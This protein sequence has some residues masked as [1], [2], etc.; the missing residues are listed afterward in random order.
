MLKKYFSHLILTILIVVLGITNFR[1]NKIL[2]GWD[3][4]HPEFLP[5]DNFLNKT[6]F[7]VWNENYGLGTVIANSSYAE[8][9]RLPLY[10]FLQ[11]IVGTDYVRFFWHL[12]L[13]GIGGFGALYFTNFLLKK[14]DI[15]FEKE[16]IGL[17]AL[18]SSFFYILN[19]GSVQ[20]N[21]LPYE[22]FSYFFM[23][24]PW[25][26]FSLLRFMSEP[27]S[28]KGILIFFTINLFATPSFSN[29]PL[30]IVYTS[31]TFFLIFSMFIFRSSK[32]T[33]S[34]KLFTKSFYTVL[35]FTISNLFWILPYSYF[36]F[37]GKPA[38]VLQSKTYENFSS[39]AQIRN[40]IGGI[41]EN[42]IFL[43]GF[44][45]NTLDGEFNGGGKYV[46]GDW[47][48]YFSLPQV[49]IIYTIFLGL[50]VTGIFYL[51]FKKF[52]FLSFFLSLSFL[53]I[54]IIL[55]GS[56]P[57]FGFIVSF[58]RD[59]VP[60]FSQVFRFSF[61][62]FIVP[63]SLFYSILL[64]IGVY[65]LIMVVHKI[66][67]KLSY[68]LLYISAVVSFIFLTLVYSYPAFSGNYF[69]P[70][71]FVSIPNSYTKISEI[72]KTE[73]KQ[74]SG[75]VLILPTPSHLAW[76]AF[77]W[78]YRGSG[79]FWFQN[80]NP[81]LS[82]TFD[83]HSNY[84]QKSFE[85]IS[86]ALNSKNIS[87]F[88]KLLQKYQI[89]WILVDNSDYFIK[90]QV[91]K[92][93][94]SQSIEK[95]NLEKV[96]E[97]ED[98]E[99]SL[100]K[101]KLQYDKSYQLVKKGA[102]FLID[103]DYYFSGNY[104]VSEKSSKIK[105]FQN[106]D[107]EKIK[108]LDFIEKEVTLKTS[109]KIPN[110][111]F[112]A[113]A[114]FSLNKT[115]SGFSLNPVL[116]KIFINEKLVDLSN[117]QFNQ[118]IL[119]NEETPIIRVGKDVY[120]YEQEKSNLLTKKLNEKFEM[121]VYPNKFISL[122]KLDASS[123]L[124]SLGNCAS[125]EKLNSVFEASF[126]SN[127]LKLGGRNSIPCV[128]FDTKELKKGLYKLEAKI[129]TTRPENLR[130]CIYEK[131]SCLKEFFYKIVPLQN[132]YKFYFY[133]DK[134]LKESKIYL[135]LDANKQSLS[136]EIVFSSVDLT[137][138]ASDGSFY[139]L[140][141][142]LT[143]LF[144]NEGYIIDI[145]LEK[146]D[147]IKYFINNNIDNAKLNYQEDISQNSYN[148]S[149]YCFYKD[150]D[151]Q[152]EILNEGG[153][154]FYRYTST[155]RP[156]CDNILLG[157]M[158][159]GLGYIMKVEY[160]NYNQGGMNL[161]LNDNVSEFCYIDEYLNKDYEPLVKIFP[162]ISGSGYGESNL[163][164]YLGSN[165]RDFKDKR[166]TDISKISFT[167][168]PVFWLQDINLTGD[169]NSQST[170][171]YKADRILPFLYFYNGPVLKGSVVGTGQGFDKGWVALCGVSLCSSLVELV[172]INNWSG[173][174]LNSSEE[175][176]NGIVILFWPQFL[177]FLGLGISFLFFFTIVFYQSR[178]KNQTE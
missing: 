42:S 49:Q 135:A 62:K 16:G 109:L 162:G 98:K 94:T 43:K 99:Q 95:L 40:N 143:S 108:D 30:F 39:D 91:Q 3:N 60:L 46:L 104:V 55:I 29:P 37:S 124:S 161:C 63:A 172:K 47:Q 51:V 173:G 129:Y 145:P 38:E 45:F 112:Y 106:S 149:N 17:L 1:S 136:S 174:Y 153:K 158:L 116:P 144:S 27:I 175:V 48:W 54:L 68:R 168:V 167:Q 113:G 126:E 7:G 13:I 69:Y 128:N 177:L 33:E 70:K 118:E 19:I 147:R 26:L 152:K 72:L 93:I 78:G 90:S 122:N 77:K 151:S 178:I 66:L 58:L 56:N 141:S 148:Y 117:F 14:F 84:N 21:Y 65:A 80:S 8:L 132:D 57:P 176:L 142:Q 73:Q 35:L 41:W 157:S 86:Y 12:L 170:T 163:K 71:L 36:V 83:M 2:S 9:F 50:V 88:E 64:S 130:I 81:I 59:N 87:L 96:Y 32:S 120:S 155:G 10:F 105:L 171:F 133:L 28:K 76:Y 25:L 85:E 107:F 89:E 140:E 164:L 31:L 137:I 61:T 166:I 4:Y 115:T 20:N 22:P 139:P 114:L 52:N 127:N 79:F 150:L 125:L 101:V 53:S 100:F 102:D 110:P 123:I 24:L 15:S 6:L 146:G 75:R 121:Y 92:D 67:P 156:L 131:D 44:W 169:S 154:N 160:V 111:S 18:L 5:L 165:S 74:S 119:N 82:R 97:S 23:V 138:S 11:L 34:K 103:T 159:S 134:D